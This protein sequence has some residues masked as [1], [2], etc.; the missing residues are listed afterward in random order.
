VLSV[1]NTVGAAVLAPRVLFWSRGRLLSRAGSFSHGREWVH[2]CE[3]HP[4]L[5]ARGYS[6]ERRFAA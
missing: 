6:V 1:E 3:R 4:G 2:R 5:K